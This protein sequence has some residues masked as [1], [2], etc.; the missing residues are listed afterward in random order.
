MEIKA[1][2]ITVNWEETPD[3]RW[4]WG[5]RSKSPNMY[6]NSPQT[7]GW[8]VNSTCLGQE[9]EKWTPVSAAV[10]SKHCW[11]PAHLLLHSPSQYLLRAFFCK[12]ATL[13]LMASSQPVSGPS[14]KC[15]RVNAIKSI[16]LS[17]M[18]GSWRINAPAPSS[19]EWDKVCSRLSLSWGPADKG[20]WTK[21]RMSS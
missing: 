1:V 10:Y 13:Y 21:Y 15:Q 2:R 6:I 16:T 9:T 3:W 17:V 5:H 12:I 18:D 11:S 14:Q 4:G 19:L 8:S 7:I 20:H